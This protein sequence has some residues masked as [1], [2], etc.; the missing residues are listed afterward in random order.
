MGCGGQGKCII[1]RSFFLPNAMHLPMRKFLLV[2]AITLATAGC[3]ILYKQPIYQGNLIE[4]SNADQLAVGQSKQQVIALLG[5]P[6]SPTCS[7]RSAGITPPPSA[8]TAAAPPRS[9]T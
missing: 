2:A 8:P 9:R 4:K 5:T 7:M 6:P 3:G 1:A